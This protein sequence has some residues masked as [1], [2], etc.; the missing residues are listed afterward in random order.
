MVRYSN[1]LWRQVHVLLV[2]YTDLK[3]IVACC[4]SCR[5][6]IYIGAMWFVYVLFMA[7]C[8]FS[9]ISWMVKKA[10][11]DEQQYEWV[12]LIILLGLCMLSCTASRLFD[13]TISRF[14]NVITAMW[15]IYCGCKLK[16]QFHWSFTNPYICCLSAMIL[17]HSATLWG[18]KFEW[19]QLSWHNDTYHYFCGSD[20][21]DL[22]F[23]EEAGRQVG[24]SFSFT[25]WKRF[26]LYHGLAFH[27][28]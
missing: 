17:Y 1:W 7:L 16:N 23:L 8:G 28:L 22:F 27:R 20:V 3:R 5:T 12:R 6:R 21:C 18:G 25:M 14:S 24:R 15:L 13:F 9:I 11:K 10:F 2:C 19:K 26:F 4:L